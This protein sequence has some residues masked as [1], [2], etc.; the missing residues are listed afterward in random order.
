MST[1]WNPGDL[2][3]VT[4][5]GGNLIATGNSASNGGVRGTTGKSSGKWMISFTSVDLQG[6]GDNLDYVGVG[7]LADTLGLASGGQ[8]NQIICIQT[9]TAFSPGTGGQGMGSGLT[10]GANTVDLCIDFTNG[11]FWFRVNGGNWNG[12]FGGASADPGANIG[13]LTIGTL[14]AA[15]FP[16]ARLTTA[17]SHATLNPTPST[18]P[19]GFT[20]WDSGPVL[21]TISSATIVG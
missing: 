2:T 20:A 10:G 21:P 12:T 17:T 8:A 3:N 1:T 5:S 11:K 18:P 13:G 14:T 6:A 15:L 19:T 4:L 7:S 16:Y 9:N